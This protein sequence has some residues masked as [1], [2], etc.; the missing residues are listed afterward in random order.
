MAMLVAVTGLLL[1]LW[2]H[3]AVCAEISDFPDH[4]TAG[5]E[6]VLTTDENGSFEILRAEQPELRI[7]S[8]SSQDVIVVSADHGEYHRVTGEV[9]LWGNVSIG[10]EADGELLA[11]QSFA[12]D[13]L[14]EQMEVSE[15]SLTLP[16]DLLLSDGL[17]EHRI[18]PR[19]SGQLY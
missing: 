5:G 4:F 14:M 13:P 19:F 8:L 17:P 11:C 9:E 10:L 16:L 15:L 18:R 2:P 6:V 3:A 1:Q 7:T 12:W